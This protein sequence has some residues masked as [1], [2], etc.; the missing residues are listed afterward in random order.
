METIE[1]D[2]NDEVLKQKPKK[3]V[4]P[5]LIWQ[6]LT[7]V[8]AIGMI[9]FIIV[10]FA[11]KGGDEKCAKTEK[12]SE[13]NTSSASEGGE[14]KKDLALKNFDVNIGKLVNAAGFNYGSILSIKT[15]A[16]GTFMI[17]EIKN[18][19]TVRF[20]IRPL[21]DGSWR[22]SNMVADAAEIEGANNT[23]SNIPKSELEAFSNYKTSGGK[24][25]YC[26]VYNDID[27]VDG[28]EV[29]E[30][31]E[32]KTAADAIKAGEYKSEE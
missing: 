25:A 5:C 30:E 10:A 19:D 12:S 8:F 24:D 13:S 27:E 26:V 2:P 17:G 29:P 18:G 16:D 3:A 28:D 22:R 1:Q 23:C 32:L 9:I 20:A 31:Q 21:P 14:T 4:N 15:N 11:G 6:I 7:G